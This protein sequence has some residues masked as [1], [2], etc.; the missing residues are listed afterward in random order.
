MSSGYEKLSS[1]VASSNVVFSL[2]NIFDKNLINAVKNLIN[3][4]YIVA[5]SDLSIHCELL[6]F[7]FS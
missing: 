1:I 7:L 6:L 5:S 2:F 3:V 4:R